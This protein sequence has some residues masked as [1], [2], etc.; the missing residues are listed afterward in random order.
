MNL[1]ALLFRTAPL[2]VLAATL[3]AALSGAASA[4]LVAIISYALSGHTQDLARWA[5]I[6]AALAL[7]ALLSRIAS[8]I[9][10]IH[11]AQGAIFQLRMQLSRQILNVPLADLER[12]GPARLLAALTDDVVTIAEAIHGLPFLCFSLATVAG[13]LAYLAWLS[14]S[15]TFSVVLLM[16]PGVLAYQALQ[17]RAL[18]ALSL[19]RDSQDALF[20]AF[21]GLTDGAKE[22][23][24]HQERRLAFL[25]TAVQASAHRSR[26][27][28]FLGIA[29]FSVAGAWSQL[30][31]LAL[32]GGVVFLL[33]S[34]VQVDVATVTAYSLTILYMLRPVDFILHILPSLARASVSLKKIDALGLTLSHVTTEASLP[35][36][37][38]TEQ[39]Q[40]L[41]LIGVQ[42]AY[43]SADDD[44]HFT[45]GPLDL[46]LEPGEILFITGG[47]GSG[48]ST[49][50]KVLVGLY[51][52]DQGTITLGGKVIDASRRDWYRQHFSVVFA[53]FYL[54]Y[55]LYGL[56]PAQIADR[57]AHYLSRLRLERQVQLTGNELKTA[58]LSQG[59]R[60]RLALLTAYLEDRPIYVFDEWASDQDPTFKDIFYTQLLDELRRRGKSVVVVSH[61]DRY[62]HVADRVV[63]LEEGRII[64]VVRPADHP[65]P[66]RAPV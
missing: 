41:E 42:R 10:L 19:A 22:L 65:S 59:Q 63:K 61:D 28:N 27:Q 21:R 51:P 1:V 16:L 29:L 38:L 49:L 33:P 50:V 11:L 30:L 13:C 14:W 8:Q 47:N 3:V 25:N 53:D 40:P 12:T 20:E 57:S 64:E 60:K 43:Q 9:M 6:F 7:L 36:P 17:R 5:W 26:Q 32:V 39:W 15:V 37:P 62:Y 34:L 23:K 55:Q 58:G 2:K 46:A 4:A 24:L 31:L 45:L 18:G 54:F 56:D 66:Q 35:E 48:K 52:P 44:R